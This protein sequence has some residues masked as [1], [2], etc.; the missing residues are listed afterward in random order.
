MDKLW[1]RNIFV[2]LLVIGFL[3]LVL[4]AEGTMTYLFSRDLK[5]HELSYIGTAEPRE[6][7][8]FDP[9]NTFCAQSTSFVTLRNPSL[10]Y[11]VIEYRYYNAVRHQLPPDIK[12]FV[13]VDLSN[14]DW[15]L[16]DRSSGNDSVKNLSPDEYE[17]E[18]SQLV[19]VCS[20]DEFISSRD[21]SCTLSLVIEVITGLAMISAFMATIVSITIYHQTPEINAKYIPLHYI[22]WMV[23]STLFS[24]A[25]F[26]SI[27]IFKSKMDNGFMQQIQNMSPRSMPLIF[28]MAEIIMPLLSILS[29]WWIVVLITT[30]AIAEL[31]TVTK[32]SEDYPVHKKDDYKRCFPLTIFLMVIILSFVIGIGILSYKL[33]IPIVGRDNTSLQTAHYYVNTLVGLYDTIKFRVVF[34]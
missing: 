24:A 34:M 9:T 15:Y 20:L 28:Q 32:Y 11:Q 5:S 23:S 16:F 30:I 31:I 26:T 14:Y 10:N 33:D 25:I 3:Q 21:V 1:K 8:A 7:G 22:I 27:E 6:P 13:M 18:R 12:K 17:Q 19:N 29:N 2:C 4:T